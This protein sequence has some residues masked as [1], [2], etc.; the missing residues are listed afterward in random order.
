MTVITI[1][2][3][4]I[5]AVGGFGYPWLL[6]SNQPGKDVALCA[7]DPLQMTHLDFIVAAANLRA[8]VY[9]IKQ[10]RDPLTVAKIIG[11]VHVPVF[12]PRAGVKIDVTEAEASSRNDA[13]SG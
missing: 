10:V 7:N 8:E 3:R 13:N 9:G 12:V 6:L 5:V 11:S 2:N 1:N 4:F